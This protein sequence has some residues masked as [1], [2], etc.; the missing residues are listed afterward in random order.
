MRK[1]YI[2]ITN[3]LYL[4]EWDIISR[5]FKKFRISH[6]EF[7]PWE[8]DVWYFY[9]DCSEFDFISEGQPVPQYDVIFTTG[10]DNNTDYKFIKA[11]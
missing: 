8:N 1:G 4:N 9:G 3:T 5:I 11:I 6:V 2:K 10:M 7:R